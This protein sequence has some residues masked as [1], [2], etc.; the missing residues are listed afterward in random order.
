MLSTIG[1]QCRLP[2]CPIGKHLPYTLPPPNHLTQQH[3][4]QTFYLHCLGEYNGLFGPQKLDFPLEW[5]VIQIQNDD[6][7]LSVVKCF[8]NDACIS[9]FISRSS[10][11]E[12]FVHFR[13]NFLSCNMLIK[14]LPF[15]WM[16]RI[17]ISHSTNLR[18]S[19]LNEF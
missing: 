18:L 10:M 11:T 16:N 4:H 8:S 17:S 5:D 6:Q 19:T 13:N 15:K 2:D 1:I 14:Q 7:L 3:H 12:F 9:Y